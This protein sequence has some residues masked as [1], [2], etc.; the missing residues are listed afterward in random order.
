VLWSSGAFHS[1]AHPIYDS[2]LCPEDLFFLCLHYATTALAF[3]NLFPVL[4]NYSVYIYS[5]IRKLRVIGNPG[6]AERQMLK[7][8][9]H[10]LAL[11]P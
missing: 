6:L 1:G 9:D 2:G 5:M 11:T 8:S 10:I 3:Y 4:T 7:F